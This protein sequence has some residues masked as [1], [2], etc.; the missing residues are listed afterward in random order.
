MEVV[1]QKPI[2]YSYGIGQA[3]RVDNMNKV[4]QVMNRGILLPRSI[5]RSMVA[6]YNVVV[7]GLEGDEAWFPEERLIVVD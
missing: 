4:G 6:I 7:E 5:Y 1:G 2:K 3:V